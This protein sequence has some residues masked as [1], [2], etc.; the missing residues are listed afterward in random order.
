[1]IVIFSMSSIPLSNL[2]SV[3][4]ST[5]NAKGLPNEHYTSDRVFDEEKKA[6][7]FENWSAIGTGKDIPNIGDTKPLNFVGMPLLM[8]RDN[9]NNISV[10]QNTC[11]HRGMILID[12]PTNIN[13]VIRCPYH[14]WCYNLKG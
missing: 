1:M 9:D 10:F 2:D 14:S 6:I 11:R 8:L 3:L 4:T 5:E 12:G 7:L 13:G